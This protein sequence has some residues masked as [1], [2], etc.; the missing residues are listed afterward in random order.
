MTSTTHVVQPSPLGPLTLVARGDRLVALH[1]A[2]VHDTPDQ[3]GLGAADPSAVPR[4]R[5]Q[6][7]EYFAGRRR[8]F[9]LDLAPD[10]TPFQQRV[11]ARL[12]QVGF[13]TTRSYLDIAMEVGGPSAVRAVG[14]ANGA[15]PIP[16]VVPC[17][18][19]VGAD[20]RLV[21]YAGGLE[22]KRWLLDHEAG[23]QRLFAT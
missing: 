8:R 6:L 19:V 17:H 22:R 13:A 1:F 7:D 12:L 18:R 3:P 10:G 11:W 14:T 5:R 23:A 20:G 2:T 21:G 16:I 15:N 9:E 4:A